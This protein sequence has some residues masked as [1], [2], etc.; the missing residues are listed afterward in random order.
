MKHTSLYRKHIE[1]G[2][3]MTEFA[4]WDMPLFYEGIREEHRAARSS[5]GVFDA[6]HMGEIE[7]TGIGAQEL[8]QRL[9]TNDVSRIDGGRVQYN[10]LCNEEGGIL[11]DLM[12]YKFSEE[13][14]VLCVNASNTE[15]D[16][17]WIAERAKGFGAEAR[18]I[19]DSVALVSVQGPDSPSAV[20]AA[21]SETG[22]DVELPGRFSFTLLDGGTEAF[23]SRTGYTGE[24]GFEIFLP[25]KNAPALWDALVSSGAAVCGLGCRDTLRLEMGY[26]LYGNEISEEINPFEANLGGY[27]KMDKGDFCGRSALEKV[28]SEGAKRSLCGITMAEPGIPRSLYKVFCGGDEAGFVT[29]GTMS[30]SLEKPVGLVM[31]NSAAVE[32][33]RRDGVE[34]Q[35]RKNRKKAEIT[36]PPFYG[37]DGKK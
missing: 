25:Q 34:I 32:T 30:P 27:V 37:K 28:V 36:D 26:T 15:R 24:D 12:V 16:F 23:I 5:C 4:G 8:C 33:A 3:K 21:L 1:N 7:I 2:A 20:R 22:A 13:R 11:D 9:V 6:S 31:I 14:F 17:E 18:D 35:I 29:S 10:L 19:S